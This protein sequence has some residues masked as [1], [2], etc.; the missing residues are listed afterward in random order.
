MNFEDEEK[1]T[2][3]IL[4]K[5]KK[6][7]SIKLISLYVELVLV[8]STNYRIYFS[9]PFSLPSKHKLVVSSKCQFKIRS[10]LIA[11]T[12]LSLNVFR[13]DIVAR[14]QDLS[15]NVFMKYLLY[16]NEKK[17]KEEETSSTHDM[18]A[19]YNSYTHSNKL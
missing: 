14:T 7:F 15:L 11:N 4:E 13:F 5:K 10:L 18:L 1:N 3:S 9:R 12:L 16:N 6:S 8:L 2:Q 19:M 17:K